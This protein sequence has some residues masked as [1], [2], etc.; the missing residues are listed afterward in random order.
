MSAPD[1]LLEGALCFCICIPTKQQT[2]LPARAFGPERR[3]PRARARRARPLCS[4]LV[5]AHHA[6][7]GGQGSADAR[8]EEAR[9]H[10]C[11]AARLRRVGRA[12][13]H[14]SFYNFTLS[15]FTVLLLLLLSLPCPLHRGG[16]TSL[17][18]WHGTINLRRP[19][20]ARIEGCR[21]LKCTHQLHFQP[22]GNRAISP[23]APQVTSFDFLPS[24][25][26][27]VEWTA[28]SVPLLAQ[29]GIS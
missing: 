18:V 20:R 1:S 4:P 2:L 26:I 3:S 12:A 21:G 29:I 10:S 11:R 27:P 17:N 25:V 22:L 23:P 16:E 6:G 7:P 14:F 24:R 13:R 9:R 8:Q 19:D 28:Q 5:A 15:V